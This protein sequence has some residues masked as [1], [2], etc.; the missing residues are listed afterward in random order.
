MEN[1]NYEIIERNFSCNQGEIDIIAKNKDEIVF[2]EV[3]TRTNRLYGKPREAVN[4]YKKI[5]ILNTA[6]YY[7]YINDLYDNYIRFDVIEV[8]LNKNRIY[9][10]H[11]KNIM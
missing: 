3:K 1:E 4:Y 2:V 9:I 5:H 6:K 7:L 8:F 11:I 10:N